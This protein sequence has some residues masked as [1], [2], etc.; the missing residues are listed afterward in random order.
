MVEEVRGAVKGEYNLA[1]V[2]LPGYGLSHYCKEMCNNEKGL[3]L[4]YLTRV[5]R[6]TRGFAVVNLGWDIN[7]NAVKEGNG[8]AQETDLEGSGKLIMVITAPG[9]TLVDEYKTGYFCKHVYKTY[10]WGKM[11]EKDLMVIIKELDFDGS[12]EEKKR[13]I[14]LSAGSL[15]LIKLLIVQWKK[16]REMSDKEILEDGEVRSIANHIRDELEKCNSELLQKLGLDEMTGSILDGCKTR[17]KIEI[18]ISNDL[19]VTEDGEKTGSQMTLTEREI[20][21]KAILN[22]GVITKEIVSDVKWGEGKYDKFS[23]QAIKKQ[24][25]RINNK[26]KS[27][28]FVA[29]PRVGYKLEKK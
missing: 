13:I 29:I 7:E 19:L 18:G 14:R 20:I 28:K 12:K 11:T 5:E 15:Q 3:G 1:I 17:T 23:D 8:M 10:F 24:I 9:K 2:G 6:I 26:L 21:E 4:K 27:Y 22:G 25:L 16:Y